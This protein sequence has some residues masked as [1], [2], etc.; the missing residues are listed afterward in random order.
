M[1]GRKGNWRTVLFVFIV[2]VFMI[3]TI[4]IHKGFVVG[5]VLFSVQLG[6]HCAL[7]PEAGEDEEEKEIRK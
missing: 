4:D 2:F 7:L 1:G 3:A 6:I 5:V